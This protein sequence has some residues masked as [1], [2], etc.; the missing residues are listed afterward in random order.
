MLSSIFLVCFL[1]G[2]TVLVVFVVFFEQR[3][4]S[5]YWQ[6]ACTGRLWRRRFPRAP[7]AEI[8]EFLDV[9][10]AAFAFEDRR[11]LC[12]GPDDRVMD[13]YRAL[14]PIRGTPDSMELEDLITR[15]QKRYG[16][17]ILASWREDI[18]LGDLFTQTRPHAAS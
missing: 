4:L 3:R 5:K 18:T 10:L 14:Y 11:R 17:E 16:V 12:F 7:K 8:R 6:R 15:L 1:V 2:A 9:F 13:V